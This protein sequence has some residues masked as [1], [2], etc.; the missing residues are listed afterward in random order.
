MA[1]EGRPPAAATPPRDEARR[2][3]AQALVY[4][5][6]NLL[7]RGVTFLLTPLYTRAMRPEDFAVV[8]V[9]NTLTTVLSLGLGCALYGC[10]PRLFVERAD[11]AARRRLFGS[12]LLFSLAVPTALTAALHAAGAAGWL[13]V[14]ATVRFV[15][16]L[17]LALWTA[18]FG[19]FAP[20]PTS[21]YMARE[22]PGK[23]AALNAAAALLQVALTL[24]FVAALRQGAL[25]VLRANLASG[26]ATAALSIAL[27]ARMSTLRVSWPLLR[28]AL[29]FSLPLVPH[30]AANWALSV[31]DRLVLERYVSKDELGRYSLG[32]LFSLVVS[33][34]ASAVTN[35]LGPMANRQLKDPRL[36]PNVP[37]LGTYA[38]A[39]IVAVGLAV[40]LVAR[41]AVALLAPPSYH[42]AARFVP[43]VV[44]GAVFQGVYFVWS[45]GTWFSMRTG[46]IPLVTFASAGLNV[47]I[48]LLLV[49]RH[50]ALVAAVSTA[51][52]YAAGALLHGALAQRLYPIPWEYRR[53]GLL[54]GVGA[55]CYATGRL[56]A[57]A[58][59]AP[60]LAVKA[61]LV[62]VAFP[63]GLAACGF[64]TPAERAR[65]AALWPRARPGVAGAPRPT[66]E[67]P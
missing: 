5:L 23:V 11:E 1:P 15:P 33:L 62:L 6:P 66:A 44:L 51:V 39:A 41:E 2:F 54:L 37:P 46:A 28:A 9:A 24:L 48:N 31:S 25:G 64:F 27:V 59:L 67:D 29:A 65:V 8:A 43:W 42:G 55:G 30:L 35:A 17:R 12:L 63:L 36:A 3:G 38:L 26:A 10:V 32:Y 58:A 49:P 45:T 21:I 16:H 57:P 18:L 14:F 7:V 52:A 4:L 40:A 19:V 34:V 20:L 53:W 47:A 61:A 50:G 56:L 22:Q 13:D 60:A